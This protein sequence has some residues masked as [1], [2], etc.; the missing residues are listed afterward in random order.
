M[1]LFKTHLT[2]ARVIDIDPPMP[3]QETEGRS[4]GFIVV[5]D[6]NPGHM[7]CQGITR[8]AGYHDSIHGG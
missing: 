4:Y 5:Y 6:Q 1:R 3:Q 7:R 8:P 2:V